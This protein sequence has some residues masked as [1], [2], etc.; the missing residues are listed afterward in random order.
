M[1]PSPEELVQFLPRLLAGVVQ[2]RFCFI[3]AEFSVHAYQ[4]PPLRNSALACPCLAYHVK[5]RDNIYNYKG[6]KRCPKTATQSRAIV[7]RV[8]R[9][10]AQRNQLGFM[11]IFPHV[12]CLIQIITGDVLVVARSAPRTNEVSHRNLSKAWHTRKSREQR[13]STLRLSRHI[14]FHLL[15]G[16]LHS[17]RDNPIICRAQQQLRLIPEE[18]R[19]A[20][21]ID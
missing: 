15:G 14:S 21:C 1:C 4:P 17:I 19:I 12:P 11:C 2:K 13:E 3:L 8:I 18:S 10:P 9:E 16:F 5:F 20:A 7:A 6:G